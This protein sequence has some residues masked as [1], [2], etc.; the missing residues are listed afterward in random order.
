MSWS[1]ALRIVRTIVHEHHGLLIS[2]SA[3]RV[4]GF[5]FRALL[6]FADDLSFL[7]S[8]GGVVYGRFRS[9]RH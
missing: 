5:I 9:D 4:I 8:S 3:S 6:G 1:S 7:K 2:N